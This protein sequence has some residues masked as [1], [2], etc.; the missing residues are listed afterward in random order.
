MLARNNIT[1]S[2]PLYGQLVI[3]PP[4][5]KAIYKISHTFDKVNVLGFN[6]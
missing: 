1:Y 3:G 5:K 2:N 6:I 4:G